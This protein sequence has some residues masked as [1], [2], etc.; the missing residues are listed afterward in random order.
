MRSGKKGL[1]SILAA[2]VLSFVVSVQADFTDYNMVVFGDFSGVGNAHIHGSAVIG[3]S[4]SSSFLEVGSDLDRATTDTTLLVGGDIDSSAF[5]RLFAGNAAVNGSG[6]V[7]LQGSSSPS[8]TYG[9]SVVDTINALKAEIDSVSTYLGGID[10]TDLSGTGL[11]NINTAGMGDFVVF[12]IN[13]SDLASVAN[14]NLIA[15]SSQ[16]I[17][18][19]V[20]GDTINFTSHLLG[21]FANSPSYPQNIMWNFVDATVVNIANNKMVGSVIAQYAA[22]SNINDFDGSVYVNSITKVGQIHLPLF[23]GDI[24]TPTVPAPSAVLLAS[25]GIVVVGRLR[26]RFTV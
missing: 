18:F 10:G 4:I 25:G 3:G 9:S 14:L 24:P 21:G 22:V 15:D 5:V 23:D 8:V 11:S 13:G 17:I 7:D 2:L 6:A 12:D 20:Y 26:R 1:Y 16:T 19:N